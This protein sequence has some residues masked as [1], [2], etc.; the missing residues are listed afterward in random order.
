M[1]AFNN[2]LKSAIAQGGSF[3]NEVKSA[4][5]A[6]FRITAYI[7]DDAQTAYDALESALYPPANLVSISAVY[8]QSGTVYSTDSLDSLKS[9][10]VVT[11][12]MSD[13]TSQT[14][15]TYALSGTLTE[16]TSTITVSYGG[17]TTTFEVEVSGGELPVSDGVYTPVTVERGKTFN[18]Q[19][20]EV[21]D[22]SN[23]SAITEE[24][25]PVDSNEMISYFNAPTRIDWTIVKYDPRKNF[26][27][28]FE[29]NSTSHVNTGTIRTFITGAS[30]VRFYWYNPSD[31]SFVAKF[32]FAKNP[33]ELPVEVGDVNA[34]TGENASSTVRIRTVG[35]ISAVNNIA[36]VGCPF[37]ESW[38]S[39]STAGG[40]GI[41]CFD[42]SKNYLGYLNPQTSSGLFNSDIDMALLSGTAY[43][44][45]IFQK[46]NATFPT[47]NTE[48]KVGIKINGILYYLN[49][50]E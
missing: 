20:G 5:L 22:A 15:T 39:W 32:G 45:F 9:D 37:G 44:R 49:E 41:R 18:A 29:V 36:V 19:T 48:A 46:A 3:S 24:Y 11:A 34:T 40:Y 23:Y 4:L 21:V 1:T 33:T 38:N 42:S 6:M 12:H 27:G 8:T 31:A 14:V 16:G 13:G 28:S 47:I 43:V 26:I 35:Y 25:I 30:Y 10:L 2:G 17:K 7:N 50:G